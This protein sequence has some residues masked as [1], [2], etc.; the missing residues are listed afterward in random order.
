MDVE[1]DAMFVQGYASQPARNYVKFHPKWVRNNFL[2]K[3]EGKEVGEY[4]DYIIIIAPGLPNSEMDRE[5]QEKDKQEYREEWRAYQEGREHRISGT[6]LELLPGMPKQRAD[7]LKAIYI[8]TIEQLAELSEPGMH[9]VGMGAVEL[10]NK[11]QAFLQK[12]SA[13]V[14]GLKAALAQRD[15]TIKAQQQQLAALDERLKALEVKP[16]RRGRPPK[17][18]EVTQ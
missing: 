11:A 4:R 9:K 1:S 16:A 8:Y 15:E 14:A 10:K 12:N 5:V 17:Q 7:S 13:E 18:P 3:Q 6:P 2:S